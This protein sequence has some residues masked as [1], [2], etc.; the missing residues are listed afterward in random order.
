MHQDLTAEFKEIIYWLVWHIP[1]GRCVTYGQLALA[2]GSPRAARIVGGIAHYG[3]SELPWHRVVRKDGGLA[4][5]YPG[6]A[7]LQRTHLENEGVAFSD[8]DVILGFNSVQWQIPSSLTMPLIVI[9][10]QTASGKSDIAMQLAKRYGGSIIAADAWTVRKKMDIGTAKP[11]PQDQAE[12]PHY[13]LDEVL[14]DE[15]FS[16]GD[17]QRKALRAMDEIDQQHRIPILVGGNGLYVDSIL[18]GFTFRQSHD[19]SLHKK[20]QLMTLQQMQILAKKY[21][22]DINNSD[23]YNKRRLIRI[24]ET[25]GESSMKAP[26][27]RP[28]TIIIGIMHEPEAYK[29]RLRLRTVLMLDKGLEEEVKGLVE[30][31]GWSS[32][33]LK[34][35]GYKEFKPYFEKKLS[36]D[37]LIDQ[38]VASNL[39]YAKRQN[40]WFKRNKSIQWSRQYED[41]DR[42]VEGFLKRNHV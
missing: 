29:E 40:T 4:H 12:V 9:V 17:F 22:T 32:E 11:T 36:H 13:L 20:L 18:Y 25:E 28:H 8:H 35:V 10:G 26:V 27:I 39:S 15:S 41:I 38:I 42:K 23:L 1:K 7:A 14:P 34:G 24:I 6:G 31:Y 5:G 30:E 2:A 16:V 19:K 37:E 33:A 21:R 3:P